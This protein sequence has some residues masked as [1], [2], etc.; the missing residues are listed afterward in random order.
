MKAVHPYILNELLKREEIKKHNA[1]LQ[2]KKKETSRDY[3]STLRESFT[4]RT[5][6]TK[7]SHQY[8]AITRKL[9]IFVGSSNVANR[10]VEN[11]EFVDLLKTMDPR[12]PVPGRTALSKEL[13]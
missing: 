7:N 4:K 11:L 6:Y 3:Q 13:N 10:I 5:G 12:Y 8:K 2:A 1:E 9:A